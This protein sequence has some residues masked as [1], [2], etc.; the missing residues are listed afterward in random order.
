MGLFSKLLAGFRK[1]H[2]EKYSTPGN[3]TISMPKRASGGAI[4]IERKVQVEKVVIKR[5][6]I[7]AW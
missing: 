6:L 7:T 1:L 3:F 4:T 5:D 2:K